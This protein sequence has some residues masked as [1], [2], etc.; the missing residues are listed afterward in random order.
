MN[1]F[2]NP[3]EDQE[4]SGELED[5]CDVSEQI[6]DKEQL[7]GL[8]KDD[9]DEETEQT[10]ENNGIEMSNDFEGKMHDLDDDDEQEQEQ[11]DY[12]DQEEL[13]QEMGNIDEEK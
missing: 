7:L 13:N 4:D 6:K 8:L 1:G 10:D 3:A 12:K 2:C 9:K 5:D 11:E